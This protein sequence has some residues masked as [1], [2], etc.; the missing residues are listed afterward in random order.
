MNARIYRMTVA[1]TWYDKRA[2]RVWEYELH[3]KVA[4]RGDI[5]TVRRRL[6]KRGVPYFQQTVYRLF[7][8]WI[9]KRKVRVAF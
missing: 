9:P 6:A 8:K 2:Q 3:F 7:Q 1:S 5:R 4:R